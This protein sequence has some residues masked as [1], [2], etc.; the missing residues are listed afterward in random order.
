MQPVGLA[1]GKDFKS[2]LEGIIRPALGAGDEALPPQKLAI[3]HIR[4]KRRIVTGLWGFEVFG[5]GFWGL[6]FG[7]SA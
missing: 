6:R 7:G 5:L 2:W 1:S 4:S 3:G